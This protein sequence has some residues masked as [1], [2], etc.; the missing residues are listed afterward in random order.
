MTV[1]ENRLRR[2]GKLVALVVALAGAIII[3]AVSA[4][5]VAQ[6]AGPPTLG[7]QASPNICGIVR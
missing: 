6:A 5:R 4:G 1:L 7:V 2:T 3:V